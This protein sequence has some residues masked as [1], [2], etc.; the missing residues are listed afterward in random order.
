[1]QARSA[2]ARRASAPRSAWGSAPVLFWRLRAL[3]SRPAA[4]TANVVAEAPA[5]APS[6]AKIAA[7][8]SMSDQGSPDA[9]AATLDMDAPGFEREKKVAS[10][11][12]AQENGERVD[13]LTVG[14]FAMGAP[15][16]RV[17]IH[18]ELNPAATDSISSST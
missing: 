11:G 9:R 4:P 1:M 5:A 7:K 2:R 16:L 3:P 15:Y 12:E 10:L 14:Q 6:P 18:P 8:A 13:S 17:D